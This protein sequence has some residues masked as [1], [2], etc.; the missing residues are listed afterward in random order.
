MSWPALRVGIWPRRNSGTDRKMRC[1]RNTTNSLDRLPTNLP[2]LPG[3][4]WGTSASSVESRVETLERFT[5]LR[6]TGEGSFRKSTRWT[7]QS[8]SGKSGPS[9]YTR[10]SQAVSGK[11][12][13]PGAPRRAASVKFRAMHAFLDHAWADARS[14]DL[15]PT[16]RPFGSSGRRRSSAGPAPRARSSSC[17]TSRKACPHGRTHDERFGSGRSGSAR[18]DTSHQPESNLRTRSPGAARLARLD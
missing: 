8:A 9:A 6:S 1:R 11:G 18:C 3:R 16:N 7:K 12:Q 15:L 13:C 4:G 14:P 2:S 5:P 10:T 17:G